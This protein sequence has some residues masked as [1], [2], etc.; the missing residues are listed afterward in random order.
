M[1]FGSNGGSRTEA[2]TATPDDSSAAGA[3]VVSTE[4]ATP[5]RRATSTKRPAASA[6]RRPTYT[7]TVVPTS[8]PIPPP[9]TGHLIFVSERDSEEN[10]FI[11]AA[12]GNQSPKRISDSG[13]D[14]APFWSAATNKII[15]PSQ[16][17]GKLDLYSMAPDGSQVEQLTDSERGIA[18]PLLSQDGSRIA[19]RID[20]DL[21]WITL[22]TDEVSIHDTSVDGFA[23]TPDGRRLATTDS[24][25]SNQQ[26]SY[27]FVV[28]VMDVDHPDPNSESIFNG[29]CDTYDACD[30]LVWSPDGQKMA[31]L[32]A[33]DEPYEERG[34]YVIQADGSTLTEIADLENTDE[35]NLVWSP[36]GQ[37]LLFVAPA[38]RCVGRGIY[39]VSADGN[40]RTRLTEDNVSSYS[41]VW[42]PD[43][44]RVA[45]VVFEDGSSEIYVMNAD[46][47]NKIRLTDPNDNADEYAPDWS[48]DGS[49][50]VFA[51]SKY[52]PSLYVQ[53]LVAQTTQLI[54][55][56][57]L[58][59]MHSNPR[60]SIDGQMLAFSRRYRFSLRKKDVTG[61]NDE[62]C[63]S[64]KL[65]I[66]SNPLQFGGQEI[67]ESN[68]FSALDTIHELSNDGQRLLYVNSGSLYFW[69]TSTS[70]YTEVENLSSSASLYDIMLSP[71]GQQM[72]YY[73][74]DED[75]MYLA[76]LANGE[77]T[78]LSLGAEPYSEK[79]QFSPNGQFILFE[80][81]EGLEIRDL[82]GTLKH[83]I[84]PEFPKETYEGIGSSHSINEDNQILIYP[85]PDQPAYEAG[86]RD[87]DILIA[88]DDLPVTGD[89]DYISLLRGEA[90]T[91]VKMTV[92]RDGEE[93]TFVVTRQII[94]RESRVGNLED[95]TWL[96][97]SNAIAYEIWVGGDDSKSTLWLYNLP[98]QEMSEV[99]IIAGD[100]W[101]LSASHDSLWLVFTKSTTGNNEIL[102][103]PTTGGSVVNLTDNPA[104]DYD[105]VWIP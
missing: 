68:Q 76:S 105:P 73:D 31:L 14:Y 49:Q 104:D 39:R 36:D 86:I 35:S 12:D 42:S 5:T 2:F 60:L 27:I 97:D 16:R 55:S 65:A 83:E 3:A 48:P 1:S 79:P 20:G 29:N 74:Y 54:A 19:F 94:E 21:G 78:H 38:N 45:Y 98:R 50:I 102:A 80:V 95:Y 7:P 24:Y 70:D 41:P 10:I 22:Q 18:N 59:V 62:T 33:P 66:I 30:D 89:T 87:D 9:L 63:S 15:F 37:T 40:D 43:S 44:Q 51:S 34:I 77:K 25:Y 28:N 67:Q 101:N 61:G 85:F 103:V 6:T 82:T 57:A 23:W 71:D 93:L 32:L 47:S 81:D 46:G 53:D 17:K 99:A 91:D 58:G 84:R 4:T 88:I 69:N 100:L 96:P 72:A 26:D 8:T 11:V 64:T 13:L 75:Q 92:L 90:G 52:G 56:D